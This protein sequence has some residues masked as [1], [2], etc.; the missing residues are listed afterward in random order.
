MKLRFRLLSTALIIGLTLTATGCGSQAAQAVVEEESYI[1]VEVQPAAAKTLVE[2]VVF[3]GKVISDQEVSIV[4]KMPGK[5]T[6]I[7][8]K[9][10][11]TVQAGQVLF[12]MDTVDLQKSVD[13]A[14]IAVKSAELSY[15]MTKDSLD[16]AKEN[17]E[18]QRALYEAGAISKV[19]FEGIEDQVTSLEN[20]LK[21]VQLQVEQAQLGYNQAHD[22]ISDMTVTAPV[23][24]TVAA[25][26]VVVG[27]M[28]S[29][30]TAAVTVT[31]L[32]AL[33]VS[34]SVPENIVN[35]LKVGQEATVIINSAG[36]KEIKG[37]LT[38]LAPAA[39][40]QLGL[41]P[42]KVTIEN[43]EN[44]V[45]P[46]MFA[47]VEIPTATKE[48]VLAVNSEAVVLKNGEYVVF[49][50]EEERAVAKKVVSGLD[51]GAEVE[52]REGLQ[53]GEQ[54]IVKGQ[55]LV[56][57]GSKVKVVGGSES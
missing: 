23:S 54:V 13:T 33:Y 1:P 3:S 45:K 51:T 22:A 40:Q 55:T 5:V 47:K 11:D 21:A 15:Q 31:Q 37:V 29:Q 18:R 39:N 36:Q 16:S 41:Y 8:V 10:G 49:V 56:E 35:T 53:A 24:G 25:L 50:V 6:N 9:V 32:D 57:Q 2:T 34:L 12:T 44:L 30:A 14:A 19:Q 26:N 42:V 28:A 38:S 27:Q 52:I 17:L 48:N 4:P 43:T 20:N 46:G 7:N